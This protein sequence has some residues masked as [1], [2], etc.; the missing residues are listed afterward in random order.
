MAAALKGGDRVEWISCRIPFLPGYR[1][2]RHRESRGIGVRGPVESP[3]VHDS[4]QA[5]PLDFLRESLSELA[6]AQR[7]LARSIESAAH[8]VDEY[9]TQGVG[10]LTVSQ[11]TLTPEYELY[12]E[13][14]SHVIITGPSSA[15][16]LTLEIEGS[17]SAPAANLQIALLATASLQP[18]ATY[19]IQWSVG[20]D[21]T[22]A[23]G[24]DNNNFQLRQGSTTVET[25][26]NAAAVGRYPQESVVLTVP[27]PATGISVRSGNNAATAGSVY[28][29]QLTATPVAYTFTLQLGDRVWPNLTLP[30]TGLLE[31]SAG[32]LRLKRNHLRILT[33]AY[34]G[35]YSLELI[36][37][38]DV[39]NRS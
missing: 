9:L 38:A 8:P 2:C 22:V 7:A 1:F 23:S 37:K 30:G 4:P 10:P 5:I 31:F 20:L 3:F 15:S 21:G 18:G 33:P 25:S 27:N 32:G 24:T 11:L 12:D 26:S 16:Q 28:T 34:A 39:R 13:L 35:Q 14:I 19:L 17:Q 29:A 6:E 36:G